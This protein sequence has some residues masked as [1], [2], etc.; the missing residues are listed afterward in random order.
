FEK[1]TREFWRI[2]LLVHQHISA[3]ADSFGHQFIRMQTTQRWRCIDSELGVGSD[4]EARLLVLYR[5]DLGI[6]WV[7]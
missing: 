3:K 5:L 2:P 6:G 7:A 1:Q 4:R